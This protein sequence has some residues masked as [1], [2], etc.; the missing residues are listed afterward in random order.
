MEQL[1]V[2]IIGVIG[3]IVVAMIERSH[4]R[5][6]QDHQAVSDKIETLGKSLGVSIDRVENT[7]IRTEQ[8]LDGHIRDHATGIFDTD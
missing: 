1:A 2:A 8:K 7:A 3:A 6:R 4:R 5:N